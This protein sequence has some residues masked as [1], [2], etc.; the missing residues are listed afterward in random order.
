M[1]PLPKVFGDLPEIAIYVIRW[2]KCEGPPNTR[3]GLN[4]VI[5]ELDYKA[6]A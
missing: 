4:M 1:S 3:F 5:F 6:S 2:I